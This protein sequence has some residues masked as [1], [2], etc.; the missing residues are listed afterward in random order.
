MG[1]HLGSSIRTIF[2]K[3]G[4]N[5]SQRLAN[6]VK[7]ISLIR[8]ACSARKES[9]CDPLHRARQ[10]LSENKDRLEHIESEVKKEIDEA[11]KKALSF[12]GNVRRG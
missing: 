2:S 11:V 10:K 3:K 12:E 9:E 5:R 7:M 6:M 4:I 1:K 8:R